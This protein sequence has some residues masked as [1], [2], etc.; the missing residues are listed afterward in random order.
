R[1][2]RGDA[3]AMAAFSSAALLP[4]VAPRRPG[5]RA[6]VPLIALAVALTVLVLAGA[7]PQ[8]TVTVALPDGAVMLVD[9]TSSS[10]GATDVRPSRLE[11]AAAAARRFIGTLPHSIR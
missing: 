6:N 11:A 8:R 4:S 5:W 1:R 9:D 2:R 10:M 7:R 3:A